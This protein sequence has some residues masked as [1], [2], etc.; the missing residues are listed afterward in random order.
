[1]ITL[2]RALINAT[3]FPIRP[4]HSDGSCS[5]G[6]PECED[7]GKH[8]AVR[9]GR[10]VL[11]G[12]AQVPI[13]SGHGIGL[14]TGE[15]SGVFVVDLDQKDG[16]NGI[17]EFMAMGPVPDTLTSATPTGGA[18]LYFRRPTDFVVGSNS[19]RLAPGIDIRGEGGY[20]VLPPSPHKRGGE[21]RW[22][23]PEAEIAEAPP[24]LLDKLRLLQEEKAR[25]KPATPAP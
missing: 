2:P 5:C 4:I 15:R 13:P 17:G 9:W 8:P 12:G 24:W 21:Y 19:N 25:Q 11:S 16:K 6:D 7:A 10:D 1:M 20:V 23:N 3:T 18:H 14:A 22:L